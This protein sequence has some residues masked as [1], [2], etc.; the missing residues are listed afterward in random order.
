MHWLAHVLGLDNLSGPWY[1]FW[2][3]SGSDLGEL[4]IV[5]A[6][7]TEIR[8][9]NCHEPRC[10]RVGRFP[11]EG[12]PFITCRHHHPAPPGRGSIAERHHL[13]LGKHPGRG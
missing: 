13:Y 12:T 1:G 5:G 4:A 9:H 2:S 10:L 8:K 7:V 11:V 6:L 3:G